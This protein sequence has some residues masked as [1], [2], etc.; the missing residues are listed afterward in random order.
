MAYSEYLADRVS[1]FFTEKNIPFQAKKM[2]GGLCFMVDEK[3]CV[4]VNTD[5]IMAR[6]NP[7]I[8]QESL[9]KKGCREM[10]FTGKPM[11]GYV[12]LTDEAIDLD[13]NLYNWLQLALGFNPLAK[14]S[15]KK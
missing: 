6:I 13:A 2:F 9:L 10:N 12:F 3:M 15:K 5:E 4:G 11:K 8:Y 7:N 14:S 1:Q